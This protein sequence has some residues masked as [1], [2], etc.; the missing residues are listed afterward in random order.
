MTLTPDRL[1]RVG[2]ALVALIAYF[3]PSGAW[4]LV[5]AVIAAF[6]GPGVSQLHERTRRDLEQL[7]DAS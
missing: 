7:R 5:I 6:V 2:V 1:Y 3:L 4:P